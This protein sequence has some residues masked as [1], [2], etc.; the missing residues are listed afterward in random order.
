VRKSAKNVGTNR[1]LPSSGSSKSG[2]IGT[3]D[4]ATDSH[5]S[6]RQVTSK[7]KG[8]P[9]AVR[10][11]NN[12][13][14]SGDVSVDLS[15]SSVA[16]SENSSGSGKNT[17]LA[18]IYGEKMLGMLKKFDHALRSNRYRMVYR[19]KEFSKA[20]RKFKRFINRKM[21]SLTKQGR[22]RNTPWEY[23]FQRWL[24]HA[25]ENPGR[26][27]KVCIHA[28]PKLS[29][30]V[31]EQ[32]RHFTNDK[33]K[34]DRFTKL[35]RHGFN[36]HPRKKSLDNNVVSE[37]RKNRV[38]RKGNTVVY[39]LIFLCLSFFFNRCF[40]LTFLYSCLFSYFRKF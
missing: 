29:N 3:K 20:Y 37:G 28:D 9:W 8:R 21:T 16:S 31:K 23:M 30:W 5:V 19:E 39:T 10:T 38:A 34:L 25:E 7:A 32:R 22:V 6:K 27:D 33:L 15:E 17:R 1:E 35:Q 14:L 26:K 12:D 13:S 4:D 24:V 36:F 11:I 18:N 40:F 2:S